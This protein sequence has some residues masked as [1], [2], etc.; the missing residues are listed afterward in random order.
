MFFLIIITGDVDILII[1]LERT[2]ELTEVYKF[3]YHLEDLVTEMGYNNISIKL[4]EEELSQED[5][6]VQV[7]LED[8]LTRYKYIFVYISKDSVPTRIKRGGLA[9]SSFKYAIKHTEEYTRIKTVCD[10]EDWNYLEDYPT[11]LN[12]FRYKQSLDLEEY[13]SKL[14]TLLE[15]I[16]ILREKKNKGNLFY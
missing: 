8:L 2:Y 1:H 10:C 14:L 6:K 11:Y 16:C 7:T 9:E 5:S 15:A 12:Y 13:K 4:L 3:K